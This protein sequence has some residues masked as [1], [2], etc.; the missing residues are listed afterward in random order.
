MSFNIGLSGLNAAQ[1]EINV[2]G[3]NI[4]NASTVGF[5][6]SRTE[7]G[8]VFAASVLGGGGNQQGSGV[9]LQN[10]AQDFSQGNVSFTGNAL[11][12]AI[13]GAGFFVLSGETGTAYTR[14]GTFGTDKDGNIINNQ[15][16]RL[17]GFAPTVNGDASGGGPLTDLVVKTGEIAP[18]A[19][20]KV[21]S[22]LNLDASAS[23]SSIVG[24]NLVSNGGTSAVQVLGVQSARSAELEGRV[25]TAGTDFSGTTAASTAGAFNVAS[26]LNFATAGGNQGFSISVNGGAFQAIDLTALDTADEDALIAHVQTQLNAALSAPNNVVVSAENNRLVLT[27]AAVGT[28]S[29]ISWC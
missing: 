21:E 25:S 3:N 10:I 2:T 17:Q 22:I 16:E 27:T 4:A 12:L 15:G 28:N 26:G 14:A 9:S 18:A 11:D 20:T 23:P 1:E 7:F 19:T 6:K 5:K 29:N 24:T 8:D 13:N